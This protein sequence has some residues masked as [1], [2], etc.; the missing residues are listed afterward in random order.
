MITHRALYEHGQRRTHELALAEAG[1]AG[2]R[3]GSFVW[4]DLFEPT[5]R[6]LD[7]VSREFGLH[8]LAVEDAVKAHQRPKLETYDDT[9]FV[10]LKSATYR[11]SDEVIELG[12]ILLFVGADFVISVRHGEGSDL[13]DVRQRIDDR[14]DLAGGGPGVVLHA[15]TDHVVDAYQPVIEGVLEVID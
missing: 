2:R 12:E 10:V 8:E 4:I 6:E 14:D 7:D 1:E 11:G 9:L 13:G 15:I 3:E 5:R